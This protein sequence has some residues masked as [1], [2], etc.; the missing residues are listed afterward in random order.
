MNIEHVALWVND[1]EK[2]REF[3]A[4]FFDCESSMKYINEKTQFESYFLKFTNGARL[5]LMKL[6][7]IQFMSRDDSKKYYGF[8]HIAISVG[9]KNNVIQLTEK[10][11][12][13]G[14]VVYSEPRVTGDG[15]FESVILDPENNKIEITE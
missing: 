11:R 5:E 14:C 2:M 1:L 8:A 9:S 7:E 12:G 6:P 13:K 4:E 3:Y 15:Y 10:I